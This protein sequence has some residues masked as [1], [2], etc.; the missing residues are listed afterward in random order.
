M[1][2]GLAAEEAMTNVKKWATNGG[3]RAAPGYA[4]PL[5]TAAESMQ[6]QEQGAMYAVFAEDAEA[7]RGTRRCFAGPARKRESTTANQSGR[8]RRYAVVTTKERCGGAKIRSRKEETICRRLLL[9][10]CMLWDWGACKGSE[11]WASGSSPANCRDE[12][13]RPKAHQGSARVRCK[14]GFTGEELQQRRQRSPTVGALQLGYEVSHYMRRT[15]GLVVPEHPGR[16]KG[17]PTSRFTTVLKFQ[18]G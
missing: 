12:A 14:P 5:L 3:E 1:A 18:R 6:N 10:Y 9:G 4:R 15:S 2:I 8:E 13:S 7:K 16:K 11:L 17:A